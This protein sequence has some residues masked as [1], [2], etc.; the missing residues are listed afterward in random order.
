MKALIY[1]DFV[2]LKKSLHLLII[3]L[4]VV[5][6]FSY[7]EGNLMIFPLIFI[8]IPV[9]LL[10]MLFGVDVQSKVDHYIVPAPVTRQA[11]VASRYALVWLLAGIGSALAVL[12]ILTRDSGV[13]IL[14]WYM[15][16]PGMMLLITLISLIQIPLMYRFGADRARLIFVIIYFAVFGLFSFFGSSQELL[17]NLMRQV[18]QMNTVV[19]SL[20]LTAV[21]IILNGLSYA[22]S[23]AIYQKL[24]F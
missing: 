12:I 4:T 15:V 24:E 16:L 19:L 23:V 8:L 3:I 11:I 20:I 17:A 6:I 10:G 14:P 22:I 5:A 7:S 1:K 18:M 9:I 13:S 21:T 2:S